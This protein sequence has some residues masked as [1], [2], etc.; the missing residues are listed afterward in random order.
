MRRAHP[1]PGAAAT[2]VRRRHHRLGRRAWWRSAGRCSISPDSGLAH[3]TDAPLVFALVLPLLLAV[4]LAE[5]SEG[6]MDVKAVAMLGVLAAIG[7][8][9]RPLGAGTAGLETV[10][11]LLVL[12]GRVFGAGF[13]FVLGATTLFAGAGHRRRRPLAAVPDA[14]RRVGR[15]R[16][17]DAAAAARPR[18]GAHARGLRRGSRPALRPAAQPVVL[19]VHHRDERRPVVRRRC[20]RAREPPPLPRLHP[21]DQPGLGHRARHHHRGAGPDH[22]Q[23]RARGAAPGRPPGRVRGTG[24]LRDT[25]DPTS[26][27]AA[28]MAP[29]R[30]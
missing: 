29:S 9:L 10:F 22:R 13:G 25:P 21:R 16:R 3:G 2:L 6:G 1:G 17:R 28:D 27:P 8:A 14:R 19:A 11:F 5:M 18:R 4:V 12:G 30:P 15:L 20:A 26:A 24:H 7:A 23:G